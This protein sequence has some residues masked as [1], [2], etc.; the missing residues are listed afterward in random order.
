MNAGHYFIIYS[1]IWPDILEKGWGMDCTALSLTLEK[2]I[3]KY[4]ERNKKNE[5][6]SLGL[7]SLFLWV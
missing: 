1:C 2:I 4:I 3:L 7:N 6:N 5:N